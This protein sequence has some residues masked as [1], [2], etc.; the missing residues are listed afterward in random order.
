MS[1]TDLIILAVYSICVYYVVRQA[2]DSLEDRT[3]I[4]HEGNVF[5]YEPLKD[6]IKI[7]FGFKDDQRYRFSDQPIQLATTITNLSRTATITIDWNRGFLTNFDGGDRPLAKITDT[8]QKSDIG[9]QS[10]ETLLPKSKREFK[11]TASGLLEEDGE[12]KVMK[13]KQPL[14]DIL[15]LRS[16]KDQKPKDKKDEP[17]IQKL[18]NTYANFYEMREPLKFSLRLALQIT[19]VFEGGK[20]DYWGFVDC[21]FSVARTPLI[22]Y[23]PWNPA[24]K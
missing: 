21:N 15:K 14:I 12:T 19:N 24:R 9:K 3:M 13:P 18:K 16:D 11:L 23:V 1:Q 22:E 5:D 6:F 8:L 4:K 17:R 20:K 10:P 2:W 7:E